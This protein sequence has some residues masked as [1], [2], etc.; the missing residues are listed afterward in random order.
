VRSLML[1]PPKDSC[2]STGAHEWRDIHTDASPVRRMFKHRLVSETE[3]SE[4]MGRTISSHLAVKRSLTCVIGFVH[5]IRQYYGG[6]GPIYAC[7]VYSCLRAS[8]L[9]N[10]ILQQQ[11]MTSRKGLQLRLSILMRSHSYVGIAMATARHRLSMD[12]HAFCATCTERLL[13]TT[14]TMPAREN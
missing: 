13:L 4:R 3:D 1:W 6:P 9:R 14:Q 2:T 7:K 5:L 8:Q 10:P 12:A 11:N